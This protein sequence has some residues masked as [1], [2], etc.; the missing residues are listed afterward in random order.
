MSRIGSN[1]IK[2]ISDI[3]HD[4]IVL[5]VEAESKRDAAAVKGVG[6]RV[7]SDDQVSLNQRALF[8]I[9]HLETSC[10]H[11]RGPQSSNTYFTIQHE[12]FL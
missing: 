4:I 5:V 7:A 12:Q 10:Y 2:Y 9:I 8:S 6:P 1:A 11:Y 3:Q